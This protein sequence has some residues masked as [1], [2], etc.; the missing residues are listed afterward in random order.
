[1]Q[2][3]GY[4][5]RGFINAFFYGVFHYP[6]PSDIIRAFL[7]L[8]N[9]P[10]LEAR[11]PM[12]EAATVD[13]IMIEQSFSDFGDADV[14]ILVSTPQEKVAVFCE[15]KR[16]K[17]WKLKTEWNKFK[18]RFQNDKAGDESNVFRQLYYKQRMVQGFAAGDDLDTGIE[19]DGVLRPVRGTRRRKIG[20]N[21]VVLKAADKL[22]PYVGS[23]YYLILTPESWGN[24]IK[25]VLQEA[26]DFG[27]PPN[28]P[29]PTGW[30]ITRWS[31]I[32]LRDVVQLCTD[33]HLDHA[34]A[35]AA[36]NEGQLF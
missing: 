14:L 31:V 16:G 25:A 32:S 6:D 8:A 33:K 26:R 18:K 13:I 11:P 28:D 12:I 30:D 19:F 1:V 34:A 35:V 21:K 9:W 20:K 7:K 36:F 22:K 27:P 2:L 10:L 23:A 4:S 15:A 3:L 24:E 29:K 17:P 5:E